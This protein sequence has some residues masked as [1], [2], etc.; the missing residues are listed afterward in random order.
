M[1]RTKSFIEL[2]ESLEVKQCSIM[3]MDF[4]PMK[5]HE[6]FCYGTKM[7][8]NSFNLIRAIDTLFEFSS[9]ITISQRTFALIE[10]IAR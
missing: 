3:E 2:M 4:R 9:K 7:T 8:Q 10:I 6:V 1:G 5:Y